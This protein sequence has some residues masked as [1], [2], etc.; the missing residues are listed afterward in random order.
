MIS[1]KPIDP[2]T[3]T[4]GLPFDSVLGQ[5]IGDTVLGLWRD[6]RISPDALKSENGNDGNDSAN[7][8][9]A[10]SKRDAIDLVS[11]S[12]LRDVL[13][14]IWR[15][16]QVGWTHDALL[17]VQ[18]LGLDGQ[19]VLTFDLN[20]VAV[21][22]E[23]VASIAAIS[24]LVGLDM[25]RSVCAHLDE[26]SR[27]LRTSIDAREAAMRAEDARTRAE[28]SASG[29]PQP[30][31]PG[32]ETLESPKSPRRRRQKPRLPSATRLSRVRPT[33]SSTGRRKISKR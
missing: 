14:A 12:V 22:R 26:A 10:R 25:W 21:A 4:Y 32:P 6:G 15:N 27:V 23:E 3:V 9:I 16:T 29:A 24:D 2:V 13:G 11:R 31:P 1:R 30:E 5:R 17:R 19:P 7:A 18:T 20:L 28:G 33:A 8:L